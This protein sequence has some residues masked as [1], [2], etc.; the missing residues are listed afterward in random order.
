MLEGATEGLC[1]T[2]AG[3]D[4]A[5]DESRD[6]YCEKAPGEDDLANAFA[7]CAG[8]CVMLCRYE[9]PGEPAIELSCPSGYTCREDPIGRILPD[10]HICVPESH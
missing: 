4:D 6:I 7:W 2:L 1:G 9:M 8:R 5:C 3:L 10:V